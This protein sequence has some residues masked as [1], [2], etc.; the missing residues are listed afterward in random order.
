MLINLLSISTLA[1]AS[2]GAAPTAN[3]KYFPGI[4]VYKFSLISCMGSAP[5][6]SDPSGSC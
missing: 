2:P 5:K 4:L 3:G 6:N 1:S